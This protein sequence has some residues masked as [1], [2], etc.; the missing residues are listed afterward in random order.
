MNIEY[1]REFVELAQRLNFTEAAGNLNITQPALSKH[2]LALEKEFGINLLDRSRKGMQ[3]TE[4][5]RILFESANIMVSEYDR[6]KE[7]LKQLKA[8]TS[9]RIIGHMEDSDIA[10]LASMAAMILR[11]DHRCYITF[12]RSTEDPFELLSNKSIDLFIGYTDSDNAEERGFRCIPFVSNHL[13]ALVENDHSLRKHNFITWEDLQG[14][15]LIKFMSDKTNPAWAQIERTCIMHGFT[16]KTR[17]VSAGNNVEFFSTPLHGGILVWKKTQKQIGLLL[18][19]GRY[20]G[21]PIA[22]GDHHLIVHAVYRPENEEHLHDFFEAAKEARLLLNQRKD[23][24]TNSSFSAS[25]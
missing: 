24:K 2:L 3:L 9:I 14:Q 10:T 11:D 25:V 13:I 12:D 17:P 16:P 23:R 22:G 5:G 18:E 7:T 20:T 8:K 15:T 19:T 1:C 6:T 21:I 4:G